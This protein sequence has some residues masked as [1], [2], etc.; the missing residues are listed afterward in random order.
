MDTSAP[1]TTDFL[2]VIGANRLDKLFASPPAVFGFF[3]FF[4]VADASEAVAS[5][6]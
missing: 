2:S 4:L 5:G 6:E 3:L 1:P